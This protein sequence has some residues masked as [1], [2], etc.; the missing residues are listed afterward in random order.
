MLTVDLNKPLYLITVWA[1]VFRSIEIWRGILV[2]VD[3]N[4]T[5]IKVSEMPNCD[6]FLEDALV[7]QRMV[8]IY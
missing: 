8:S 6:S 5:G 4:L 7:F 3:S 1:A 2:L